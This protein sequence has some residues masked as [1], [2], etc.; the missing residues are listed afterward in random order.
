M[1]MYSIATAICYT[2]TALPCLSPFAFHPSGRPLQKLQTSTHMQ[3]HAHLLP[4]YLL[5]FILMEYCAAAPEGEGMLPRMKLAACP[6]HSGCHMLRKEQE[7]GAAQYVCF[8][9]VSM[10]LKL[11]LINF[12]AGLKTSAMNDGL[13]GGWTGSSGT[14]SGTTER[15][16]G[17]SICWPAGFTHQWARVA[18]GKW[19]RT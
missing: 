7:D 4:G 11:F 13:A 19:D 1:Q 18:E 8:Q 2:C 6:W 3:C 12:L 17:L 14:S 9:N 16:T 15:P 5:L 10:P